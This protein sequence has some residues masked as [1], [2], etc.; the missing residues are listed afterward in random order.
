MKD[1]ALEAVLRR[2]RLVVAGALAVLAALAWSYVLWLAADMDM[3]GTDMTGFRIRLVK[4]NSFDPFKRW[5][6][7]AKAYCGREV[8]TIRASQARH[9]A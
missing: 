3:G 7:R 5:R 6:R 8:A 9:G 1:T 4:V 2:D